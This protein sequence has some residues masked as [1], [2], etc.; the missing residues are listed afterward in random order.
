MV[1]SF[2]SRFEIFDNW[3]SQRRNMCGFENTITLYEIICAYIATLTFSFTCIFLF[4]HCTR[5]NNT[6]YLRQTCQCLAALLYTNTLCNRCK[7]YTIRYT[8]RLRT[9]PQSNDYIFC[10]NIGGY[11]I[12]CIVS[13]RIKYICGGLAYSQIFCVFFAD[14]VLPPPLHP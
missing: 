10:A 12:W 6:K 9:I 1:T 5:K 14:A 7:S 13:A 11:Q 2:D 3:R 4:R 8:H